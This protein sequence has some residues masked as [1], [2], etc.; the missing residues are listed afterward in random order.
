M[1]ATQPA[2]AKILSLNRLLDRC[3]AAREQGL[4]I[5]H[6]HGCFDIVHPGH[7]RHLEFAARQGDILLVSIS[8][9][10]HIYKGTGRPLIPELLRA[11][12]LAALNCVDWV[13]IDS[14]PTALELIQQV[15]PDVYLKGREYEHNRDPR[16]LAEKRAVEQADGRVVFSSGDIVFS[17]SALIEAMACEL[18]PSGR[19][20][21]QLGEVHELAPSH[22][23]RLIDRF[24]DQRIVVIGESIL[25]TYI[26]CQRP[27]IASEGP[28]MTL[29]P[30]Q[31][32]HFDGGA[33]IICQHLAAL[34]ANATLVTSLP[35]TQAAMMLVDR[36][37]GRGVD[38]RWIRCD[39]DTVE[40]QRYLVGRQKVLKV[41]CGQPI[42]LDEGAR[43]TF[44]ELA[45]AA[46]SA[47]S[48][49]KSDH[50]PARGA[51]CPADAVILCD[52][53]QGLLTPA[54]LDR[55][56]ARLRP[57]V[58][59]ITGD[60]SGPRSNLL[61]LK[62]LDVVCP[63]EAELRSAVGD[64]A[65]GLGAVVWRWLEATDVTS[66]LVTLGEEGVIA[67]TRLPGASS[68]RGWQSRLLSEH[69]PALGPAAVDEL[70]CG[71][72]LLATVTLGLAAGA[73]LVQAA[74]L[75]SLAAS[76]E[77]RH[78]GNVPVGSAG[79]RCAAERMAARHLQIASA[80]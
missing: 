79:L 46:T 10:R 9:D 52:Y 64:F 71:D 40:K 31:H 55:L 20:L 22:L 8:G 44:I 69:I 28:M 45:V 36:L 57:N 34:G 11:E 26:H 1:T 12:N 16:F 42:A 21:Q 59:L 37:R 35:E 15:Q 80:I 39:G 47:N 17:S 67:F 27:E 78:I 25:D 73:D 30:M 72:A 33:A 70:G 49:S 19:Q 60:V 6:C 7:I 24:A 66:A 62:S 68:R 43:S 77:A 51:S 54:L 18:D 50:A 2:L 76:I 48:G 13:H 53:G 41:D 65:E 32:Q 29:R 4:T 56:I 58:P 5:V 14:H 75:G 38:V 63:N 23:D 61:H 74:Y 3:R